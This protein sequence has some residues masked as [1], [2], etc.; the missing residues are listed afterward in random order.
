AGFA[1]YVRVPN[2]QCSGDVATVAAE[3]PD[4]VALGYARLLGQPLQHVAFWKEFLEE[5]AAL[6]LVGASGHQRQRDGDRQDRAV[7]A[8]P[9]HGAWFE[10]QV[11]RAPVALQSADARAVQFYDQ[12]SHASRAI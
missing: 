6:L 1:G 3:Q 11:E 2:L 10:L 9:P 12:F 7:D 5:V 8:E 4:S